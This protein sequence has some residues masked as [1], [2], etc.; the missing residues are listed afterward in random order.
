[1]DIWTQTYRKLER[2]EG[3]EHNKNSAAITKRNKN[4]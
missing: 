2:S 3:W 1:M 4:F